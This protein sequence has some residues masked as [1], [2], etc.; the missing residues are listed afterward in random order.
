MSDKSAKLRERGLRFRRRIRGEDKAV[1]PVVAT[2]ILILIA[3]A[4]AAALY[5]WLVTWQG[6]ITG[7]IGVTHAQATLTIGGSTSVYPFDSVAVN[8]FQQNNSDIAISNN[9]GGSG[10]GMLAVCA[11][12]VDIGAASFPVTPTVLETTDGCGAQYASTIQVTT[13]AY[14]AVDMIVPISNPHGL[15]SINYDTVALIYEDATVATGGHPTLLTTTYDG[16]VAVPALLRD[17][18]GIN[19]NQIPAAVGGASLSIS[20]GGGLNAPLT[21]APLASPGYGP[22]AVLC[23]PSATVQTDICANAGKSPCGQTICAGGSNDTVTTYA[24]SDASGTTQSFEARLLDAATPS[25]FATAATLNSP[26]SAGFNGCGGTNYISDCAYVATKTAS[27]NPAVVAGVAGNLDGIGYASDGIARSAG[28]VAL[29]SFVGVGQTA[30]AYPSQTTWYGGILPTTGGSGTIALGIK[31]PAQGSEAPGSDYVMGYLGWRPFDLVTL[32][33][34]TA[35]A[36]AFFTFV[37]DPANNLNI[38]SAAQ[39][40]SIYSV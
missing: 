13:V 5:L 25:S 29:V 34:P 26:G 20:V 1:S 39:E 14:D 9:Q 40:V 11:G 2:L 21:E 12:A 32:N 7:G 23:G 22:S 3:V 36:A 30:N 6:S 24:R 10:A 33:T 4:A 28:T 8:W 27:G 18:S 31:G 37:L 16:G 35:T 17:V 38:A 19:W 15:L